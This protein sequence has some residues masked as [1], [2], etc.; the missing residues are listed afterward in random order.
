MPGVLNGTLGTDVVAAIAKAR[1]GFQLNR[2]KTYAGEILLTSRAGLRGATYF[3][4][5]VGKAR[6]S[7]PQ[8]KRG[9][10]R[11]VLLADSG[12]I[13]EMYFSDEHYLTGSWR[14]IL[15]F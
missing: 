2:L 7:E 9:K 6:P 8:S 11:L 3:E 13:T 4:A 10:Q 12:R 1:S 14:G 15:D 5:D